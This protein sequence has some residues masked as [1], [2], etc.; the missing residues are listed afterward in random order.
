MYIL[1]IK[2]ERDVSHCAAPL[3]SRPRTRGKYVKP[4]ISLP[5]VII[6]CD[7]EKK[8]EQLRDRQEIPRDTDQDLSPDAPFQHNDP[9]SYRGRCEEC[10]LCAAWAR[11]G[12]AAT[13]PSG[14]NIYFC[15]DRCFQRSGWDHD[16]RGPSMTS[17]PV[18]DRGP[19]YTGV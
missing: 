2:L 13:L 7:A 15:H 18:P 12:L 10:N 19:D 4:F 5:C 3:G 9:E 8:H 14:K 11:C 17:S 6:L 16:H 1:W